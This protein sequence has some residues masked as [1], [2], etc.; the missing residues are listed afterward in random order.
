MANCTSR[1][2]LCFEPTKA[3]RGE[4][5]EQGQGVLRGTGARAN[6]Q[7]GGL[8]YTRSAKLGVWNVVSIEDWQA[9]RPGPI[10]DFI[11]LYWGR[12]RPPK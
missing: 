5:E 2:H 8:S 12:G 1:W 4:R 7:M 10:S 9:M 11:Y 6:T 3:G